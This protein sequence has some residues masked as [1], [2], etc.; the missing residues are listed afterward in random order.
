MKSSKSPSGPEKTP[1]R[2][3]AKHDRLFQSAERLASDFSLFPNAENP[4]VPHNLEGLLTE[5]AIKRRAEQLRK[6]TVDRYV[7]ETVAPVEDPTR[8]SARVVL[9]RLPWVVLREIEDGPLYASEVRVE[10]DGQRRRIGFLAQDRSR[11]NGAWGPE[12]HQLAVDVVREFA[13]HSLPIVCLIDTPGAVA[14][15]VANANNQAHSISRLIAEMAQIHVP[16]VGIILGN[17]YSGGAIPLATT[18]ILLSVTDGVFNTIQPRGLA[19]IARKYNLSWQECAQAVGVSPFELYQQGYLDGIIDYTPADP[20][21]G[22]ENLEQAIKSSVR[23]IEELASHFVRTNPTVLQHY[24]RTIERYLEPVGRVQRQQDAG[25][26]STI[27]NPTSQPNVFGVAYRYLR[28]LAL[29]KKVRSTTID[30]YGRLA[31]LEIPSGDLRERTAEEDRRAFERW[32]ENPLQIRYDDVLSAAW[33]HFDHAADVLDRDRGRVAA[34]FLGSREENYQRSRSVLTLELAFHLYNLWK[35]GSRT[36]FPLLLQ[37]LEK[38]NLVGAGEPTTLDVPTV[39]SDKRIREAF[40]AECRHLLLF[41]RFYD[42]LIGSLESVAQEAMSNNEIS[43]ASVERLLEQSME[44]AVAAAAKSG[45]WMA[46]VGEAELRAELLE[47]IRMFVRYKRRGDL[48]ASVAEWKKA[49]FPTV[50]EPL[51]ALITFVLDRL[52]PQIYRAETEGGRYDGRIRPRNIGMKDFW[53]RLDRAYKDLLIQQ[54]LIETKRNHRIL[55]QALIDLYFESF[56]ELDAKRMTADPANFPGFRISIEDALEKGEIPCGTVSGIANYRLERDGEVETRQVGVMISNLGFQAGSFDM[57]SGEKF[58]KLLERCARRQLPVICFIS[59]GGMQTKEGAGSLF[60]MAI[61]NDRITRFVRDN[62]LPILMFGFGDCTGGAQ[63]SMVTHPLVDTYYFSGTN[64]PFA[65]QIVVPSHLPMTSTLSNYLSTEPGS[66][67]GLV[68]HPFANDLDSRLREVDANMP[69]PEF[70]VKQVIDHS[71]ARREAPPLEER[72]IKRRRSRKTFGE[73]K[74]TLIHARGCTA[75]KLVRVAM[76]RDIEVVL[77]QSDPDM[78]SAA[79]K[80]LGDDDTLVCLGGSTPDESYLNAHSVMRIAETEEVDSIHPGIGFLSENSSFADLCAQH[81]LNF[82]GPSVVSMEWMGNKSNAVQTAK[83]LGVAVVPG[84]HGVVTSPTAAK[85]I[86]EDIGYPVMIKAVHGGGGRGIQRVDDPKKFVDTFVRM[87]AE[88]LSAFGSRD[89]YLEKFIDQFRHVEVQVLRDSHGNTRILGLRDC[90]VQ[91]NQ[92]KL[93]EE[94]GSTLLSK[95]LRKEVFDS[96]RRLAAEVEYVG[97]GTVEFIFDLAEQKIYFMEMNTRLQVEHPVTEKVTGVDIVGR[98]FDIA[99]GGSIEDVTGEADPEETGF[100]IEVRINAEKV[101]RTP[102]GGF[103]VVPDP[104]NVTRFHLPEMDGIDVIAGVVEG[105]TVSPYYDNLIAQVIAHADDRTAAIDKLLAFLDA[106]EIQGIG[107]N[108]PL[109]R[110]VLRDDEF[111]KGD[112][113]T[114]YLPRLLKRIDI[115]ELMEEGDREAG[116]GDAKIDRS[117]LQIEGTDELKVLAASQG[118]FYSS[119]APGKN[120]FVE[121]GDVVDVGETLCLMEAMKLFDEISLSSFNQNDDLYPIDLRYRIERIN[122]TSGQLVNTGDLLFVIKP[123]R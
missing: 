51:F 31:K 58:A 71:L 92:Q 8:P 86:A 30:R 9:R 101:V 50:S 25:V 87:G 116:R 29:R 78:E 81:D 96:A 80:M 70:T 4:S 104:G 103:R 42:H 76:Q 54:I 35:A 62:N 41:D 67:L 111:R 1:A 75:T 43:R 44:G 28:Y 85:E 45:L 11:N 106:V 89:L 122:C 66:M 40:I 72:P 99:A 121:V 79:A 113:D 115:E 32:L 61:V 68:K 59:S 21:R 52:L 112:H 88:A 74:R 16:T 108:A 6:L 84:S 49:A 64:M 73:V 55:P 7:H 26:L 33:K 105:G 3:R 46:D 110:R 24:R 2:T 20:D 119:P 107:T 17:G 56:Q 120:D 65:G 23:A 60:S 10:I 95:E 53:H 19:N 18:N 36:N 100:A 47:W 123:V 90:S 37:R 57:A 15:A 109:I 5:K 27:D 38:D 94:S 48:L 117:S 118:I 12:H 39:L 22:L 97:A 114:G 69:V 93:V 102:E 77:V 98:Q 82:I 83:R 14:N 91:R 13:E 63:A 34:F